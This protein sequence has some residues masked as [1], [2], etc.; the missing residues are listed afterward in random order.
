MAKLEIAGRKAELILSMGSW[1]EI[2]EDV[3]RLDELDSLMESRQ[4]L[5][6]IRAIAS[7]LAAEGARLGKGE[8]MPAEWL[9]ENCPPRMVQA[10]S[11]AIRLAIVEGMKMETGQSE[12]G[13][14]DAVMAEI[15]K[16]D[17]QDG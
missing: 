1:E 13:A 11:T 7:I 14:V 4:R 17:N 10:V 2:E 5:R 12:D 9:K 15:E 6:N 16:K 3:G 8:E